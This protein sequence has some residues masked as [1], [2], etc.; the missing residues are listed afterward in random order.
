MTH[1]QAVPVDPGE[2][3]GE[4]RGVPLLRA[5]VPDLTAEAALDVDERLHLVC[6]VEDLAEEGDVGDG[7]AE[8]VDLG[9]ALLVREGG[10]VEAEL[11]EG[12]VDGGRAG[13]ASRG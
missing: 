5:L 6:V 3:G 8:G 11:L 1:A 13:I 2:P 4:V 7:E 10:H 12:R 9:E